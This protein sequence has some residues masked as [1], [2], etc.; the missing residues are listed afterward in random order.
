VFCYL[1]GFLIDIVA[2]DI[3]V[4][5]KLGLYWSDR[6][7]I[8]LLSGGD[9]LFFVVLSLSHADHMP[10]TSRPPP[11]KVMFS[12]SVAVQFYLIILALRCV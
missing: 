5:F 3:N 4:H 11:K 10:I 6:S 12:F 8:W 7:M 1:C 9:G 2:V